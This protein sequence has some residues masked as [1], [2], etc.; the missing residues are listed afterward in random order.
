MDWILPSYA[1]RFAVAGFAV[2]TFDYRCFGESEGQPRQLIDVKQQ[3]ED[4][5]AATHFARRTE[6]I[7]PARIALWGT[8]LGGGHVIVVAADDPEIAAVI[9]QVPGIDLATKEARATIKVPARQIIRL[10]AAALKDAERCPEWLKE[11][12]WKAILAKDQPFPARQSTGLDY[13]SITMIR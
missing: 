12:A 9:A 7:D 10:L 5:R 4:I 2:L 6:G 13:S 3:R 1:E 8:S 11:H